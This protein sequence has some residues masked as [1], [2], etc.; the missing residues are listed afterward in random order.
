MMP[1]ATPKKKLQKAYKLQGLSYE[2]LHAMIPG[3]SQT[4]IGEAMRGNSIRL[5][6]AKEISKAMGFADVRQLF[7]IEGKTDQT[8]SPKTVL[9]HHRFIS[10]VLSQAEKEML[11][12]YNA[13]KRA[14]PPKMNKTKVNYFEPDMIKK[15]LEA[16]DEE[17]FDRRVLGY[18]L[19]Y[20]GARRGEILGLEWHNVDF[21]RGTIGIEKNVLYTPEKGVYVDTLKTETSERIISIPNILLDLLQEY[22]TEFYDKAKAIAG[23]A[24]PDN[25]FVFV[26]I[27]GQPI[28]PD[29]ISTWLVRV[30]KK[31]D[32]PHLNTHAFRHSVA[33]ALIYAG[34]DPVSVS[35]RL[36]HAQVS[37]TTNV[38]AHVFKKADERNAEILESLF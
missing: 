22:K 27:H 1:S 26:N 36:G 19:V 10:S 32:L 11:V 23:S 17:S 6:K 8:L 34:V 28:H 37:T 35:R 5:D 16:F 29:A 24:W 3:V 7:T 12:P 2:R 21:D 20:T 4:V 9:E 33:S 15:I 13:A 14:T 25:D 31:Y 30:E 38:Y 18:T